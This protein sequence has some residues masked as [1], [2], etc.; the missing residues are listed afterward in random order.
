MISLI[1]N[2]NMTKVGVLQKPDLD[3]VDSQILKSMQ[4]IL[5]KPHLIGL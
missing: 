3:L 4:D 1:Y 5:N 2:E